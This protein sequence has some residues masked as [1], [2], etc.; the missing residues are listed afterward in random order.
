MDNDAEDRHNDPTAH[1][2]SE[3]LKNQHLKARGRSNSP[4]LKS[5][6]VYDW[7]QKTVEVR[8]GKDICGS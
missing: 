5:V 3:P 1:E 4:P 7:H 8:S 6:L 2:E